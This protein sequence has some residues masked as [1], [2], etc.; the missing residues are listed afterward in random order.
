ME[1]KMLFQRASARLKKG[2]MVMAV[3]ELVWSGTQDFIGIIHEFHGKQIQF[4]KKQKHRNREKFLRSKH[5]FVSI[6]RL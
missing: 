6:M 2:F 5:G 3:L 1:T 4:H